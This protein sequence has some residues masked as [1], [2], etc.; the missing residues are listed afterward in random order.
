VA[1]Q[2]QAVQAYAPAPIAAAPAPVAAAA[3]ATPAAP[4]GDP[5]KNAVKSPMVGTA[6]LSPAPGARAFIE[7][8]QTVREGQTM[9]IIEAMKT[10]NQIPA[11]RS[12]TVVAILCEDAQPVEFG[13]P[14][15]V[16]E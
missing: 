13:E 16:I 7:V 1:R 10:M 2:T 5:L 14:L 3:A 11:P 8:G 9:L 12:G 15:V 6:Y 4:T